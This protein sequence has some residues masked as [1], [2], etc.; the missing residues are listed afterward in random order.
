MKITGDFVLM[1]WEWDATLHANG[2]DYPLPSGHS[3]SSID[4]VKSPE[5][6]SL[7]SI[8]QQRYLYVE[9]G[10]LT[11][12]QLGGSN[13]AV[14]V[15]PD[16]HLHADAGLAFKGATGQITQGAQTVS[17]HDNA[18]DVKGSLDLDAT[19]K[20]TNQP[21]ATRLTGTLQRAAVDGK[22]V[23]LGSSTVT[24]P[25][26]Q[27]WPWLLGA[28]GVVVAVPVLALPA[29][30]RRSL[31]RHRIQGLEARIEHLLALMYYEESLPL[32]E[33]LLDL[34]PDSPQAHQWHGKVLLQ[35]GRP[36]EALRHHERARSLLQSGARDPV[37]VAENAYE[38]ARAAAFLHRQATQDGERRRLHRLVLEW[39]SQGAD[40]SP[41]ILSDMALQVELAPFVS[42]LMA[43][44]VARGAD[45]PDWL[46]P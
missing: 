42:E 4:P 32:T 34:T 41:R 36:L 28:V 39:V 8:D 27:A 17:L 26:I 7:V 21:F 5:S 11:V 14:Y 22:A 44:P 18:L 9:N 19:G 13:Y 16:A 29:L 10:T 46:K 2:Q 35:L 33:K 6:T 30:R 23:P 15:G 31:S 37:L 45:V 40:A 43:R 12:P 38:A 3:S 20:D 25:G 24:G 1:L